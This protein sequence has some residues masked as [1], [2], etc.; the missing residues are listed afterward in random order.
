MDLTTFQIIRQELLLV[1]ITLLVVIVDL[2]TSENKKQHV[3]LFALVSF[4]ILTVV[5]FLPMK[6]GSLF[7]GMYNT[8][9]LLVA[10]KNIL[11][12]AMLVVLLQSV[13][14]LQNRRK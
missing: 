10:M 3:I 1:L 6:E 12:I 5:G 13:R 9:P 2:A 8:T 14:W 7:G 4:G 11:N